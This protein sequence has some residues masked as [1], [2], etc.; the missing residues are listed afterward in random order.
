M[1]E[2]KASIMEEGAKEECEARKMRNHL[3]NALKKERRNYNIY[4]DAAKKGSTSGQY[5]FLSMAH[6]S[7]I[8]ITTIKTLMVEMGIEE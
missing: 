6:E 8:K 4:V 2:L 1:I 5:A 7:L 3:A